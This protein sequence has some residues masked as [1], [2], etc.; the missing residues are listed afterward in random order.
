MRDPLD[1]Y[2]QQGLKNWVSQTQPP[3]SS[4]THLLHLAASAECESTEL[5]YITNVPVRKDWDG[6]FVP[7]AS[8]RSPAE[9]IVEPITQTRLWILHLS[10]CT[11]LR[12]M[13]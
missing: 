9:R 3:R 7:L 1:R 4:R 2:I 13:A 12:S 10:P 5:G 6:H 8:N 11:I